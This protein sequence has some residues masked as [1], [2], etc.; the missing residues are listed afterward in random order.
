MTDLGSLG[1]YV[2]TK[3]TLRIL[4]EPPE[5]LA[6]A[7]IHLI[8]VK[9]KSLLSALCSKL[10]WES[11]VPMNSHGGLEGDSVLLST[12]NECVTGA[13]RLTFRGLGLATC[14][15]WIVKESSVE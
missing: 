8:R 6:T 9:K 4:E 11:L 3:Q 12:A 14:N 7:F 15:M 2:D 10:P 1:H 13:S 5:I